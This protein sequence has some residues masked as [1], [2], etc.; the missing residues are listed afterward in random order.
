MET[1][2]VESTYAQK[3]AAQERPFSVTSTRAFDCCEES[4][5]NAAVKRYCD[6]ESTTRVDPYESNVQAAASGRVYQQLGCMQMLNPFT[7]TTCILSCAIVMIKSL[8]SC[9]FVN[10]D[11]SCKDGAS[12][13]RR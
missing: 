11:F 3:P 2:Q 4:G 13:K 1:S 10:K 5:S 8:T 9:Q 12:M 6:S 7:V